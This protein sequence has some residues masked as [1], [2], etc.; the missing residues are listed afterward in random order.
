MT[1]AGGIGKQK[2]PVKEKYTSSLNVTL[3][4]YRGAGCLLR[5]VAVDLI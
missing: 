5:C 1:G 4:N 2:P 3:A